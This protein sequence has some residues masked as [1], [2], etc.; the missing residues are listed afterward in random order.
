MAT[1]KAKK[2]RQKWVREGKRN[3]ED[4]RSAFA[5]AD[6]RTRRTK[7]KLEQLNRNKHK[8]HHF[9]PGEDGSYYLPFGLCKRV[10]SSS[11]RSRFSPA[12]G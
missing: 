2:L 4:G 10:K 3:P 7:S 12:E 9:Y 5:F 6:M 8:N 11:Y 1:S